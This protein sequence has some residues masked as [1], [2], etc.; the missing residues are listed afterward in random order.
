MIASDYDVGRLSM[1][2]DL[3]WQLVGNNLCGITPRSRYDYSLIYI[4]EDAAI[5]G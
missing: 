1:L 5:G 3:H 4:A 2:E